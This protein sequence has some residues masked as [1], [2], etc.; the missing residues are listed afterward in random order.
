MKLDPAKKPVLSENDF[1]T[2]FSRRVFCAIRDRIGDGE[3]EISALN[4]DFTPEEVGRIYGMR[5]RRMQLSDNGDKVFSDCV[6]ALKDA[7]G[8][9]KIAQT[10]DPMAALQE[11]LKNKR[12]D[13]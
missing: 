8:K 13:G 2:E 1:L 4:E 12:N 11:I 10:D 7:V 3:W 9:E 5:N 6:A